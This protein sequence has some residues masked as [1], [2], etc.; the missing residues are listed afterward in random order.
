MVIAVVNT[1]SAGDES[2]KSDAKGD[3]YSYDLFDGESLDGWTAENGCTATANDGLLLLESG[4]G[5]LRTDHTYTDFR[6]ELEWKALQA[7][8]YDAGIYIRAQ[9]EGSPFPKQ[10]YQIN[11]L[12]GQE[13]SIPR[14]P[15]AVN[16][17]AVDPQGEWNRFEITVVG[18]TVELVVNGK[19]AYSSGGL[20]LSRG[21]IGIQ[22]EVPKGGQFLMRN[23]RVTEFGHRSLFDGETLAGWTGGGSKAEECWKVDNRELICTGEKGPWLRS[24]EQY[25]DFNLRLEY[26]VES[27]GNS[28]VY[29]RVPANGNHHRDNG[30]EPPAGFEVQVLDDSAAQYRNL[31]PYQY[32]A[33][34]Y[35]F[36]G[37]TP[38][39]GK[40]PGQWNTLEINCLGHHIT[41]VHNGVTVVDTSDKE[42]AGLALRN[43]EGYLGLQNH[44][45][46][47]KF[48][49]LRVGSAIEFE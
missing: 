35:D 41:T 28:G 42:H 44:K 36:A 19:P 16:P 23:L 6:L 11:L 12:Q 40:P 24:E 9:P 31:K 49:K 1:A 7:E 14:M 39:V 15:T 38:H 26:Q 10:A 47:V 8:A 5:W 43:L 18:E 33:S 3:S 48:R 17:V 32:C 37:A 21:H 22:I 34:V 30:N 45:T 46:V 4:N 13:G 20:T 29:V 27:G 25:D 2:A